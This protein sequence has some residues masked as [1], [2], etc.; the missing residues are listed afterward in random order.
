MSKY[1]IQLTTSDTIEVK[2]YIDYNTINELVDGWY[3]IGGY[4]G[5]KY[6]MY[7]NEEALLEDK[8]TFN[9]LAT[10]I[11][12]RQPIYGNTVLM[13]D[14]YNDNKERDTFPMSIEDA[15]KLKDILESFMEQK[16]DLVVDMHNRFDIKPK[17]Y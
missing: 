15:E 6:L 12:G 17:L 13:I 10:I 11:N 4:L 14:G 7:C 1:V 5:K 9:A 16:K 8:C 3:E 2:E